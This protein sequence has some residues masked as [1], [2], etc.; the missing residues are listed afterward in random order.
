VKI[1]AASLVWDKRL[2]K[3]NN[4]EGEVGWM[5]MGWW[6]GGREDL[7]DSGTAN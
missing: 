7:R 4:R 2:D 1:E 3:Q 6:E 5:M